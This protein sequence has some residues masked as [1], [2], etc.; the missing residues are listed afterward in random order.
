M[1]MADY[2]QFRVPPGFREAVDRAAEQ[3]GMSA[4]EFMRRAVLA[5]VDERQPIDA[6]GED[7]DARRDHRLAGVVP[8]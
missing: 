2:A 4:S 8:G 1:R 7:H 6:H 5:E 3:E